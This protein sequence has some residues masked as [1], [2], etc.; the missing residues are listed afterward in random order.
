MRATAFNTIDEFFHS[1]AFFF[2]FFY[3][4]EIYK[5]SP[6]FEEKKEIERTEQV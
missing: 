4:L 5:N 1:L 3:I 2:F 6:E